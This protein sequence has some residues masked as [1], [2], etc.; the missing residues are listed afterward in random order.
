MKSRIAKGSVKTK[1]SENMRVLI[2]GGLG[3]IGT[4]LAIRCLQ[5]NWDV[6]IVDNGKTEFHKSR[7]KIIYQHGDP[8]IH[9][10]SVKSFVI[11]NKYK[12]FDAVFHLAAQPSVLYSVEQPY[13]SFAN[14]VQ[15]TTLL[16]LTESAD[17]K[18]IKRI[19]FASSAAVYG[20]TNCFPTTESS[21][22]QPESPY[23]LQKYIGEKLLELQTRKHKL[24]G[25]SLRYFNV[26]GPYQYLTGAYATAVSAWLHAIKNKQ[27]LRKDGTGEQVRDMVFVDDV[28]NA[29]ILAAQHKCRLDGVALNIASGTQV[30]NNHILDLLSQ[31]FS[32]SIQNAPFRAGDVMKTAPSIELAEKIIGYKPKYDFTTGLQKTIDSMQI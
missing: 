10:C 29:N 32:F 31:K 2:T 18:N 30:S 15:D 22:I 3:F 1:K 19:I 12:N 21:T 20:N 8:Q 13:K 5:M 23:G 27:P 11:T 26:Y 17:H 16:L 6:S 24:D 4:N 7:K 9:E 28:V 25:V 14:N